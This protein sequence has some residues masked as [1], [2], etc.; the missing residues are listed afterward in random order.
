[1]ADSYGFK[2]EAARK[3]KTRKGVT[4]ATNPEPLPNEALE[5]TPLSWV[6]GKSK[7]ALTGQ[8]YW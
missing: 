3:L 4:C 5:V 8:N 7:G 6:Y 2:I 1:M